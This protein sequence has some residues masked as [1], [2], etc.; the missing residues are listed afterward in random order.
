MLIVALFFSAGGVYLK[1][2]IFL[3]NGLINNASP[4]PSR[5]RYSVLARGLNGLGMFLH[6]DFLRYGI[7]VQNKHR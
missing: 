4:S 3:P 2:Q 6:H 5:S 7:V 1:N